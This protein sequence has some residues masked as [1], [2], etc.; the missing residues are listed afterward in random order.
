MRYELKYKGYSASPS[1]YESPEG[2]M[3]VMHN[4]IYQEGAL[5]RI[6]PPTKV[7]DDGY[8]RTYYGT[9]YGV[10]I[11]KTSA[12]EHILMAHN[13]NNLYW[14]Q[15]V[16]GRHGYILINSFGKTNI[17]ND[18]TFMGNVVVVLC[19]DGMHYILWEATEDDPSN[20]R[21]V[22]LGN[23][24]PECPISFGLQGEHIWSD[25]IVDPPTNEEDATPVF[26][27][28]ANKLIADKVTNKG[29]F[30]F[31]FFVRYAY[32]LFDGSLSHHSAPI[33]M[34]P[35]TTEALVTK[36]GS[37]SGTH[38]IYG[39]ATYLDYQCLIPSEQ[40]SKWKSIIKSVDVFV[41]APIYTYDQN[42]RVSIVNSVEPTDSCFVG[43]MYDDD[44]LKEY[45]VRNLGEE[46]SGMASKYILP[47][48]PLEDIKQDIIDCSQFYLLKSIPIDELA[49]TKRE[50]IRVE[51]DYLQSLVVREVMTDDYQTH[52]D[53][54]PKFSQVYNGRLNVANIR[55]RLFDGYNLASMVCYRNEATVGTAEVRTHVLGDEGNATLKGGD[56]NILTLD[57]N[58]FSYLYYPDTSAYA[59]A[60]RL[61]SDSPALGSYSLTPH[62]FLNGSCHFSKFPTTTPRVK[63][64]NESYR[65]GAAPA[66]KKMPNKLFS[67]KTNNPFVF[68]VGTRKSIGTG[69]LFGIC[70]A[71]KAL[72]TGQ[73][74]QFPL[75]AFTTEGVWALAVSND[76]SFIPAQPFTRDVC[77]NST[78]ITQM[79]STVVFATER[80]LMLLSGSECICISEILDGNIFG[81]FQLPHIPF[82]SDMVAFRQFLQNCGILFDYVNQRIIVFNS[83]RNYAYVYSLESKTWGMMDSEIFRPV[84]SYPHAYAL[85]K[86]G[87][88]LNYSVLDYERDTSGHIIT[89][90]IRCENG[91]VL[92]TITSIIQRGHFRNGSVK[93][94]LY[95]SRN[96]FDWH[97]VAS[98]TNHILR[99][100][101]GTPYKYFRLALECNL[102]NDESLSGCTIDFEPKQINQTR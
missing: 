71:A 60:I 50:I 79:D 40:L 67:S 66:I 53:L 89:R 88:V 98:S 100:W 51:D 90:P 4:I 6:A 8:S 84:K 22:Y 41:S 3:A 23:N 17:I 73:F 82:G 55:R 54:I 14:R 85:T 29:R 78:S 58:T 96:L 87:D 76:G 94:I 34:F 28:K 10:W 92:K 44:D 70:S 59:M 2:E 62:A 74:G 56:S 5:R 95:G 43:A 47:T 80:G 91:D 69:E 37:V 77:L 75:Y 101:R 49:T 93:T 68:P 83:E 65:S 86:S 102:K 21:Y 25:V 30:I 52:D 38:H 48:R 18:I 97:L 81:P 63:S 61:M 36:Q 19:D 57:F 13:S 31:P 33:L 46:I 27:A 11:H 64:E 24:L 12:F 42:G 39:M 15:E 45:K 1:D 32:R 35:S 99:G 9:Y 26:L 72:S 16:D 7:I 20:R